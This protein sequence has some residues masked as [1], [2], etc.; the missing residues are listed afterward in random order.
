LFTTHLNHT[1]L[2]PSHV[3]SHL[4][5]LTVYSCTVP[6]GFSV[7]WQASTLGWFSL[8]WLTGALWTSIGMLVIIPRS[9]RIFTLRQYDSPNDYVSDRFNNREW[10][11]GTSRHDCSAILWL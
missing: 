3:E 8:R 2:F 6:L 5:A 9:Y 7:L 4:L 10:P 1:H 11:S